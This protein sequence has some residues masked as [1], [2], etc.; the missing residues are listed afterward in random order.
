MIKNNLLSGLHFADGVNPFVKAFIFSEGLFWSSANLVLPLFVLFASTQISNTNIQ[1]ATFAL[2]SH[3]IVRVVTEL[4]SSNYLSKLGEYRKI[5]II[6][7]GITLL[8]ISYAGFSFTNTVPSLFLFG[9]LAGLGWGIITPLKLSLFSTHLDKN[10]E[11]LEWSWT[12]AINL[13]LIACAT[14]LGGFI[15]NNF[16]FAPLFVLASIINTA[17]IIPFLFYIKKIKLAR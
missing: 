14:A 11:T 6:I 7:A 17:A 10:K 13:T 12:D 8:S 1:I 4:F 9:G 2:S 16:G 15:T 3:F 5:T